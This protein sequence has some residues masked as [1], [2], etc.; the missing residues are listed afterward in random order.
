MNHLGLAYPEKMKQ[1]VPANEFCGDF[2]P[3][4]SLEAVMRFVGT[5]DREKLELMLSTNAEIYNDYLAMH[6]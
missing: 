1:A 5:D 4:A 6:I 3:Q 2:M